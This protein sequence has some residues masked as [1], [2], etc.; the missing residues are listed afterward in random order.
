METLQK[1]T[2]CPGV[3]SEN[4]ESI[5]SQAFDGD[6][7]VFKTSDGQPGAFPESDPINSGNKVIRSSKCTFLVRENTT[8]KVSCPKLLMVMVLFSKQVM[9]NL[10]LFLK[11]IQINLEIKSSDQASVHFLL[12]KIQIIAAMVVVKQIII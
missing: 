2:I 10:V 11:V 9:A 5:L 1:L 12:E 4:Y 8:M 7:V 3:S 6:G